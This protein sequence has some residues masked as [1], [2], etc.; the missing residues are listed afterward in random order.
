MPEESKSAK[1]HVCASSAAMATD[2]ALSKADKVEVNSRLK[3]IKL[4]NT[5]KTNSMGAEPLSEATSLDCANASHRFIDEVSKSRA[6]NRPEHDYQ[7][8]S[9]QSD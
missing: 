6:G 7:T 9:H 3:T 1:A 8:G 4:G 2:D 5:S